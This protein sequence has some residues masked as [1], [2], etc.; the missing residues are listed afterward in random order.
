MA[1]TITPLSLTTY[2]QWKKHF[3]CCIHFGIGLK[4]PV[5]IVCCIIVLCVNRLIV[6]LEL[7]K[8]Q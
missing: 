4:D 8:Q 2:E 6:L 3:V 7:R 1:M 5:G